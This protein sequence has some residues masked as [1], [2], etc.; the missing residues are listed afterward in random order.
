MGR[1]RFQHL[2][3]LLAACLL[4]S[5]TQ[6]ASMTKECALRDAQV[7]MRIEAHESMGARQE[8]ADAIFALM[9]ARH[10]C[11]EGKVLEALALYDGIRFG[12][13]ADERPA[14]RPH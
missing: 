1:I 2:H 8:T 10:L 12:A 4:T 9:Q 6:A 5:G 7:L 3:W 11:H 13:T 14:R